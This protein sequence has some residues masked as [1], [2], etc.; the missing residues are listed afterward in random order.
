M[1]FGRKK[2]PEYGFKTTET[3]R[4]PLLERPAD[5][6]TDA[7]LDQAARR[8]QS[9]R[10]AV[11]QG[12]EV[13]KSPVG[14]EVQ[15]AVDQTHSPEF[16]SIVRREAYAE[17]IHEKRAGIGRKM[18][19]GFAHLAEST[20]LKGQLRER[21]WKS[22]WADKPVIGKYLKTPRILT[23]QGIEDHIGGEK[24][25]RERNAGHELFAEGEQEAF[26]LQ[27]QA[28]QHEDTAANIKLGKRVV[29]AASSGNPF[30]SAATHIV[31]GFAQA[32]Q[33]FQSGRKHDQAAEEFGRS[34]EEQGGGK[35]TGA[36]SE[37]RARKELTGAYARGERQK[38]INQRYEAAGAAFKGVA[39]A[40]AGATFAE[41]AEGL[42]ENFDESGGTDISTT[43][44][45]EN[46]RS[47][48]I[49]AVFSDL[50]QRLGNIAAG[51]AAEKAYKDPMKEAGKKA[52]E[53]LGQSIGS[54]GDRAARRERSDAVTARPAEADA[55]ASPQTTDETFLGRSKGKGL[56]GRFAGGSKAK[57]EELRYGAHNRMQA[58][59]ALQE[60]V[61]PGRREPLLERPYDADYAKGN[62]IASTKARTLLG[63]N[64]PWRDQLAKTREKTSAKRAAAR[65]KARNKARTQ[66]E[67]AK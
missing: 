15:E 60:A 19:I 16:Q 62:R 54:G 63:I 1:I 47:G 4:A 53:T 9:L 59:A 36:D 24:L 65:L 34:Y 61:M 56:L 52:G 17:E 48:R 11:N 25:A 58:K 55:I 51:K 23:Q 35:S 26:K 41:A 32:R 37:A 3:G 39:G 27:S 20:G 21:Q 8:I 64:E 5:A 50:E 42:L 2:S 30:T 29:S 33:H 66:A 18:K 22:S 7:R 10:R 57:G 45:K 28:Y 12:R 6:P 46:L 44:N 40:V 49:G 31:A 13:R 38:G 43:E 67:K 14:R